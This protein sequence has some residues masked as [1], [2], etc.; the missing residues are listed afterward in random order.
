[1]PIALHEIDGDS[2]RQGGAMQHWRRAASVAAHPS[3]QVVDDNMLASI[4]S[5]LAQVA[6]PWELRTG[7]APADRRFE[8]V[9]S[10]AAYDAWVIYW[11]A[12]IELE[13]HDHGGSCGAFAVV[14]GQL[15][16]DSVVDGQRRTVRL[17]AGQ[18]VAFGPD[19]VHAVANRTT[20]PATSIHVYSPP[21]STMAF[22]DAEDNGELRIVG[23]DAGPWAD[24][25]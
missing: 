22:Y 12:G 18:T 19:H 3:S 1:M 5:G 15:D 6:V 25:P 8:R 24:R 13:L 17:A 14:G 9:L 2:S 7:E 16:E 21:L 11:P 20:R 4:A 23:E 10:T